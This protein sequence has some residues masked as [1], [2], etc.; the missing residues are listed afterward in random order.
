MRK[1]TYIVIEFNDRLV[2]LG[3]FPV[4][5]VRQYLKQGKRSRLWT[6][7]R[8]HVDTYFQS[9]VVENVQVYGAFDALRVEHYDP[10]GGTL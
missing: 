4:S 5:Q 7:L 9:S 6:S 10:K 1:K 3:A 8:W 2:N